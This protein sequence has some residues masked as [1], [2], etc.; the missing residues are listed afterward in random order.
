MSVLSEKTKIQHYAH[1]LRFLQPTTI[2]HDIHITFNDYGS[3]IESHVIQSRRDHNMLNIVFINLK[4]SF[5]K[6]MHKSHFMKASYHHF[7][8]YQGYELLVH[9]TIIMDQCHWKA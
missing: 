7:Y 4:V 3:I 5:C 9:I 6:S 2:E 1:I 8:Q